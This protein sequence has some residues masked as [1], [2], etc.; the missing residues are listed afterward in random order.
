MRKIFSLIGY[1]LI[2]V[3]VLVIPNQVLAGSFG[4]IPA[5]ASFSC[6][7]NASVCTFGGTIIFTNS[8]GQ[9]L[10]RTGIWAASPF[11][12][13][14]YSVDYGAWTKDRVYLDR[15]VQP[16]GT[17]YVIYRGTIS[18][19][20]MEKITTTTSYYGTVYI[21][22]RTCNMNVNPPDCYYYGGTGHDIS[23]ALLSPSPSPTPSPTSSP[24][25]SPSP[26][27]TPKPS[28]TP[29]ATPQPSPS[30]TY[31]PSP[32]PSPSPSPTPTPR[33]TTYPS[34]SPSATPYPSS[35]PT[36]YPSPTPSPSTTPKPS[37]SP[38]PTAT[39]KPSSSPFP[40][41]SPAP[42]QPTYA[43]VNLLRAL[44]SNPNLTQW[45][46]SGASFEL[47]GS[48]FNSGKSDV[49]T[50]YRSVFLKDYR[51]VVRPVPSYR[52]STWSDAQ[53]L[54]VNLKKFDV[55]YIRVRDSSYVVRPVKVYVEVFDYGPAGRR[56]L[57]KSQ[58]TSI[59]LH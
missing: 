43:V 24:T 4:S 51:G 23:I 59:T 49:G 30:P 39:P 1:L 46:Y 16:G 36:P 7:R 34:P 15:V 53:I 21:D 44:V 42:S 48:G 37:T 28:P 20:D 57:G 9:D 40:S 10:Y 5:S 27:S 41:P 29:T 56:S 25:P 22:G 13:I 26:S 50:T 12:G 11:N 47:N 31:R 17:V 38:S 18:N 32:A 33:P 55:P 3:I 2:I 8:T 58:E 45:W 14:E 6:Q 19:A 54:V 35:T 52:I